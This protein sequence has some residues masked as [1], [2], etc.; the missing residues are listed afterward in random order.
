MARINIFTLHQK[1]SVENMDLTKDAGLISQDDQITT[2]AD[3]DGLVKTKV[4]AETPQTCD[5][6]AVKAV[7]AKDVNTGTPEVA[8]LVP[9]E[10]PLETTESTLRVSAE[11][12]SVETETEV[13]DADAD[14]I[15]VCGSGLT[16]GFD[17]VSESVDELLEDQDTV[18][19]VTVALEAY[20]DILDD[21]KSQ[22]RDISPQLAQ[23]MRIG[24]E[25]FDSEFFKETVF[26]VEDAVVPYGDGPKKNAR[27]VTAEKMTGK[28]AEALK[29]GY[30]ILMRVVRAVMDLYQRMTLDVDKMA[31]S[32]KEIKRDVT[33]LVG[34]TDMQV[35]GLGRLSIDG[36]FVGDNYKLLDKVRD[37]A[38]TLLI[39]WPNNLA[40]SVTMVG[41]KTKAPM[42]NINNI[43]N[44]IEDGAWGDVQ[45]SIVKNIETTFKSTLNKAKAS[46]K[47][48]VP[49]GFLSSGE[50]LYSDTLPGGRA[51]YLGI[52]AI[53]E[54]EVGS[55]IKL[56]SKFSAVPGNDNVGGEEAITTMTSMEAVQ[57]V[58]SLEQIVKVLDTAV[59]GNDKLKEAIKD[60]DRV[61][62]GLLNGVFLGGGGQVQQTNDFYM[63]QI[64][65]QLLS[66]LKNSQYLFT[67]YLISLIKA[68]IAVLKTML[69]IEEGDSVTVEG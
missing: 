24:L 34:G 2:P 4:D 10:E 67:G 40:S 32:L 51:L 29:T 68:E 18:E 22:K 6:G 60:F 47:D 1:A 45:Q 15:E 49:S 65:M 20:L 21:L 7:D 9:G 11:E 3:A 8:T 17:E 28:L 61:G 57:V 27:E 48:K 55:D 62:K 30:N 44:V 23:A 41:D 42:F 31:E 13:M 59:S 37:L 14:Y 50:V 26:S 63:Y 52:G 35:K 12:L 36:E 56:K 19:R 69:K 53:G 5:A 54:D 16:P 25:S 33:K 66:L 38:T 58:T 39:T 46:D 64:S 43:R